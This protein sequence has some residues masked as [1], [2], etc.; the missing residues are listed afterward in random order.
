MTGIRLLIVIAA[1][2]LGG[3]NIF[4]VENAANTMLTA[5]RAA[6]AKADRTPPTFNERWQPILDLLDQPS[7]L[8][9]PPRQTY[10]I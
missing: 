7:L 3:C 9:N 10:S 6:I 2:G 5:C 4:D 1:L 8:L